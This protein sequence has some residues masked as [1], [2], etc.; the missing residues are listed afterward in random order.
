MIVP[1]YYS[2][3]KVGFFVFNIYD[4]K[5]LKSFNESNIVI[6]TITNFTFI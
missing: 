6:F 1:L 4:M 5:H 3:N 2:M